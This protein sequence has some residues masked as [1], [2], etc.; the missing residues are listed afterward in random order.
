MR[1]KKLARM[2]D[3]KKDEVLDNLV[4]LSI[5][6]QTEKLGIPAIF[7]V[8]EYDDLFPNNHVSN[9]LNL[10]DSDFSI[11]LYENEG[12]VLGKVVSESM[13]TTLDQIED[14]FQGNF[15][16]LKGLQIVKKRTQ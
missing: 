4:E 16:H 9:L 7:S 10:L 2:L 3:C 11:N 5:G 8:G 1:L 6:S 15:S 12:H 13:M 14:C